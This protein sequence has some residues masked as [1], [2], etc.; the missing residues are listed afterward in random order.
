[1]GEFRKTIA[2]L[3]ITEIK[4][5]AEHLFSKISDGI[6]SGLKKIGLNLISMNVKSITVDSNTIPSTA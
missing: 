2:T 1:M 5:E 4:T 3:K 6:I